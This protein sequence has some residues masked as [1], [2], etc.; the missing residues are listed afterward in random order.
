MRHVI[1]KVGRSEE[2]KS[3][4]MRKKCSDEYECEKDFCAKRVVERIICLH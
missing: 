1:E 4:G 3:R 2:L